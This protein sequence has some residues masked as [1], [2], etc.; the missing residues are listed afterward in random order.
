MSV[1]LQRVKTDEDAAGGSLE[2]FESDDRW[3]WDDQWD[4]NEM[5]TAC[6][7]SRNFDSTGSA[8]AVQRRETS[9]ESSTRS[10]SNNSLI[11][12]SDSS[13]TKSSS[14]DHKHAHSLTAEDAPK[15]R[16]LSIELSKD[17][18]FCGE[19]SGG[20]DRA[21]DAE[22]TRQRSELVDPSL[23][24]LTACDEAHDIFRELGMG[25]K[26]RFGSA[27]SAAGL[28]H[29]HQRPDRTI[30]PMPLPLFQASQQDAVGVGWGDSENLFDLDF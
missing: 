29:S 20:C 5:G 28:C 12:S 24:P 4:T 16:I 6:N 14:L 10:L 8:N 25:A 2:G 7:D 18:A 13:T 21:A 15:P 11:S 30:Q 1:S 9:L 22:R 27:Q 17:P 19:T 23:P 26:P 3:D